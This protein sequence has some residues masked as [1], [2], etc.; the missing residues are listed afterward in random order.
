MPLLKKNKASKAPKAPK[1]KK[2]KGKIVGLV[3]LGI[4]VL[5]VVGGSIYY[6]YMYSKAYV[7]TVMDMNMTWVL[8]NNSSEGVI[9]DAAT[10]NIYWDA[11]SNITEVY[12][13]KGDTV[14]VGD[15]LFQYD[16]ESLELQVEQAKLSLDVANYNL[17][18][19]K[20]ELENTGKATIVPTDKAQADEIK[21]IDEK[22]EA[23]LKAA[24]DA[25][26]AAVAKAAKDAEDA[27]NAFIESHDIL[28]TGSKSG[29]AGASAADAIVYTGD[30]NSIVQGSQINLWV[31]G[32]SDKGITPQYVTLKCATLP[33]WEIGP[34]SSVVDDSA[35]YDLKTHS[36]HTF[37]PPAE[38]PGPAVI[39]DPKYPEYD[40]KGLTENEK[41]EQ[42]ASDEIGIKKAENAVKSAQINLDD[43]KR[44]LSEATVTAKIAGVILTM[45]DYKNPPQDGSA[46]ITISSQNGLAVT[47][48][49]SELQLDSM[50]EGDEIAINSWE[51]GSYA[52]A[53]I[54]EGS[55]YPAAN[56][57][58]WSNGNSNVSWYPYTAYIENADGFKTGEYVQISKVMEEDMD[59]IVLEKI[60]VRSDD[61]GN[62]VLADNGK[63][64]LVK[65]P[66]TVK[67][68]SDSEYVQITDGLTLDDMIAFPYGSKA[69][70]GMK[71]TT[72]MSVFD[73]LF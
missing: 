73:M 58:G 16:T 46:F 47:G 63:G 45:G 40:P 21:K 18:V 31:K 64:R 1:V 36:I 60:Y 8:S 62:Y 24:Q 66:V 27:K 41:K 4:V 19:A 14:A 6:K 56:Y 20:Q 38:V 13:K 55:S 7:Q 59:A 54:T 44:R 70:E 67:N 61:N 10:Q 29:G 50:K 49:V 69:K 42:T 65:K 22:H 71:T 11:T 9:Q 23:D 48:Y 39:A 51:S 53:T 15:K 28:K 30:D 72:Q 17:S 32:N 5:A 57:N 25:Y 12:V 43:A 34:M 68:T 26:D 2:H 35:W 52:T 3:I 33:D 37:D